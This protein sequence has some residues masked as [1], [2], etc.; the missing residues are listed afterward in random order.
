MFDLNNFRTVALAEA[1]SFLVL[2]G[3]TVIKYQLDQEIGVQILGPVHGAL[4]LCYL[5]IAIGVRRAAG[6]SLGITFL[7]L[8]GAV[9]PFGGFI[10]DKL[11][12]QP[13]IQA[14]P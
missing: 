13:A 1:V 4:F 5:A 6:W 3:A 14:R 11:A 9:V 8:A 10:V 12:I 2:L 7:I